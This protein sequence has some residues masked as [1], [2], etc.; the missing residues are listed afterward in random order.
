[1]QEQDMWTHSLVGVRELVNQNAH[2]H[3]TLG[4]A[5]PRASRNIVLPTNDDCDSFI[6]QAQGLSSK[7]IFLLMD[8]I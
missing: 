1:M 4:L 7:F 3:F 8:P 5:Q 2:I 6:D